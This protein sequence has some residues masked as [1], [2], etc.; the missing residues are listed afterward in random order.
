PKMLNI[1]DNYTT[2]P[3]TTVVRLYKRLIEARAKNVHF[4]YYDH[5]VDI[6]GFYRGDNYHY[7]GHWSWVYLHANKCKYDYDGSTIKLDGRPV[8][9]MEWMAAQH[10]QIE[11]NTSLLRRNS[12]RRG[13]P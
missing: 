10:K 13:S 2:V 4:S 3:E 12:S 7:N 1:R 6:T 11:I 8:T 9:V 5:V